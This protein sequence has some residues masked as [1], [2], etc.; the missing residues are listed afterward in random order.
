MD[1]DYTIRPIT[2]ESSEIEKEQAAE[3]LTLAFRAHWPGAWETI[4]DGREEVAEMLADDRILLAAQSPDGRVLGWI[5][6]IPEYDGNVWELHPLAVYPDFQG[7]GIGRALVEAFEAEVR[8]RG[9]LT[10]Q[11]G[12]D[13]EDGSTSLSNTDL[14]EDT[15]RK[16]AELENYADH[17]VTFYQKLGYKL[18]GV[19]P[20][21]NGIGKPDLIMGKRVD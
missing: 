18:I 6:G 15:Y 9:G 13:D 10:I 17:P 20:D 16:M 5:G 7:Q 14:Y 1:A 11:L 2:D 8:K 12:T 21:A 4:E 3:I 19:M